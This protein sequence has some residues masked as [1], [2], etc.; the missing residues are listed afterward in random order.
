MNQKWKR[1]VLTMTSLLL[2]TAILSGCG[3]EEAKAP[4]DYDFY[5]FNA[6]TENADALAEVVKRYEKEN[7]LKIKVFSL[8][9]TDSAETLRSEMNSSHKPA[10]FSTNIGSVAEWSE[11]KAI[12]DLNRATNPEL[13]ELASKIPE[14]MRLSMDG[15]QNYG[16]PY[17]IEG[18]GLIIDTRMV[19]GLFGPEHTA[20]FLEDF[21]AASYNEFK[22]F[23]VA[24]DDYIQTDKPGSVSLN[25]HTYTFA[26]KKTAL[27]KELTGV[28]AE[29]GAE[30]WTYG[31]H[32][33][34][35]ALNAVFE[36]PVAAKN[37][38]D[39]QVDELL[40]PVEKVVQTLDLY[41]QHAAGMNGPA[42]R[43]P[44]YIN[45]T[46]AS[47]DVSV[48]L[49]ASGKALLLKQGNWVYPNIAK[50]NTD[51][52]PH[53]TFLPIKLPL[54]QSDI[55]VPGLTVE[56]FNRSVPEFVPSYYAINTKVTKREQDLAQ[57]FLVWLNTSEEGRKAIVKDFEFIPYNA[58]AGVKL[59]NTLNN[60]LI[61]YKVAG[62]T[63]SNPFNGSPAGGGYWGQ[64]VFGTILQENYLNSPK[65]W[66]QE[67][68]KYIA[69]Q[70]VQGWKDA[71]Y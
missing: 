50:L 33:G 23:V 58:D 4:K 40:S 52:L 5:I 24:V 45:S 36:S 14:S 53:L 12:M 6:K 29:A 20:M 26:S 69:E 21:K 37:A 66:T 42:E 13:K 63:L 68:Y 41:S 47:Y 70:S 62:D 49:F 7:N 8:G 65:A 44:D 55:K 9:T 64:E 61:A 19:D 34:N 18:Y 3:S 28:F 51:I 10:I 1:V 54:E 35:M 56:K 17:N 31:D 27:T 46:T 67:D 2:G 25:G 48:Q 43:G 60:S 16:I 15:T 22:S 39:K 57:Q 11:S 38:T 59:D 30:K 71:M 32:M